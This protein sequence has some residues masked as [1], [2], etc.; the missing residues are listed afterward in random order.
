LA[1]HNPR[2]VTLFLLN[3]LLG[4]ELLLRSQV[5]K[6]TLG[7][8]KL[9]I[10]LEAV[11]VVLRN[12]SSLG[13]VRIHPLRLVLRLQRRLVQSNLYYVLLLPG[14]H[15]LA[16]LRYCLLTFL[17]DTVTTLFLQLFDSVCVAKRVQRVFTAISRWRNVRNHRCL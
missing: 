1:T 6:F 13:P 5:N 16:F 4:L 12:L 3:L 7:S 8:I 14:K 15:Q 2:L 9:I 17:D 10:L 11:V